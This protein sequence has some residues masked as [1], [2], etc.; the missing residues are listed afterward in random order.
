MS[1]PEALLCQPGQYARL[2]L[3]HLIGWAHHATDMPT[4]HSADGGVGVAGRL[5][6]RAGRI[7]AS[8]PADGLYAANAPDRF[9]GVGAEV[10]SDHWLAAGEAVAQVLPDAVARALAQSGWPGLLEHT[11]GEGQFGPGRYRLSPARRTYYALRPVLPRP[12]IEAARRG[13]SGRPARAF[14]LGW[15]IEDRYVRFLYEVAQQVAPELPAQQLRST[16]WPDSADFAFVLTHDVERAAGQAFVRTL[17]DIDASYGFRSSFNFVLEDYELDHD[18]VDELVARGFEVGIHG[19]K[20]DGSLFSSWGQFRRA[21]ARI[22][23]HARA[24]DAVG[25]RSPA[26][27]R[28]PGWMQMLEIEYDSSFFDTDP[29]EVMPGGTMSI[30]PFF[31][32][33]FVELPYTL[34]QDHTLMIVLGERTPRLWVDKLDFLIKWGGMALLNAHPDY[35]QTAQHRGVYEEFLQ[36]VR[37]RIRRA[38]DAAAPPNCWHALPRE[39]ARWWRARAETIAHTTS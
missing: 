7:D 11:L 37:I 1:E 38:R 20:H 4:Q 36:E 13:L 9:W 17:A 24:L 10:P 28:H 6:A 33:R 5:L 16:L 22:A 27:H 23:Q 32:G 31:C 34:A 2:R 39:V 21:G 14:S 30:W 12:L 15:P 35:L 8:D 26:T 19:L 18:L 25:F 3:N 29:Y